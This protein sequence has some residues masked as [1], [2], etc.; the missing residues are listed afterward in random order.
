MELP[1]YYSHRRY[2]DE[3]PSIP[4]AYEFNIED[5]LF[6]QGG[7]DYKFSQREI[8]GTPGKIE[9]PLNKVIDR[10]T[11]ETPT[12]YRCVIEE[13]QPMLRR[14]FDDYPVYQLLSSGR[15]LEKVEASRFSFEHLE[16]L[17]R[18]GLAF[19][20]I[21]MDRLHTAW[22]LVE[23]LFKGVKRESGEPYKFHCLATAMILILEFGVADPNV[24]IA[25]LLH[26]TFEDPHKIYYKSYVANYLK[27]HPKANVAKVEMKVR[28]KEQEILERNMRLVYLSMRADEKH[29]RDDVF[30]MVQRVTKLDGMS[31]VAYSQQIGSEHL[32][33][34][35]PFSSHLPRS[36]CQ[37]KGADSMNN[38]RTPKDENNAKERIAK[39][40]RILY[41]H[42]DAHADI[43][44]ILEFTFR[45]IAYSELEKT[46]FP[47]RFPELQNAR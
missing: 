26:D 16:H 24:I 41:P 12:R 22:D 14:I 23:L 19:S 36:T 32:I 35:L 43:K 5:N 25:G 47:W 17:C 21:D 3:K 42:L 40:E 33:N 1:S 38:Y 34:G 10:T 13:N 7:H 28:E 29:T 9:V 39:T 37:L 27:K 30:H 4:W 15:S 46:L 20:A 8:Q 31:E 2:P 45:R 6:L 44:A 11:T 18:E